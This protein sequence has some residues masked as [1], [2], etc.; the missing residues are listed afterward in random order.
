MHAK[1]SSTVNLHILLLIAESFH[2]ALDCKVHM[3]HFSSVQL[4]LYESKT[5]LLNNNINL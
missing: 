3:Q 1:N 4:S 2:E 5:E